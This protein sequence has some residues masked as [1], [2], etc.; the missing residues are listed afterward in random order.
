MPA[1]STNTANHVEEPLE[2]VLHPIHKRWLE[3]ARRFLDPTL[4][5]RAES[6][7]C[8]AAVRYLHEEFLNRFRWELA[9]VDELRPFLAVD[10]S[11]R[12]RC[13]G[14]RLARLRLEVD[15]IGHRRRTAAQVAAAARDLL[16]QLAF[17]CAE[18]EAAA[19][20]I[21]REALTGEA[22]AFLVHPE[23]IRP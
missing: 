22:A 3:E 20:A 15:R 1:T 14:A 8:S 4:S 10:M 12:L 5:P 13:E 17:W 11:E 18:I 23:R 21:P 9:F 2:A 19:G 16:E 6:W 7:T